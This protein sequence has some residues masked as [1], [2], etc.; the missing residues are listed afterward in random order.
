MISIEEFTE[1]A[2]AFLD[3]HATPRAGTLGPFK[4]GEGSDSVAIVEEKDPE[5]E[6][7]SI[8]E[9][10]VWAQTRWDA[11][12]GWITGP[13]ELGGA[14]LTAEHQRAYRA[15]EHR[16][17][18]P[19]QSIFT[20]GLGMVAPTIAAHATDDIKAQYLPGLHRGD[21]IACQLFSEPGAGSDLAGVSMRAERDGD[22]WILNGQK[23]WTSNAQHSDIGEVICRTDPDAPKHAGITAFVVDMRAPGVEVRPLRQMT[24]GAAF[25]EVFLSDVRVPD[26][27]RLG[28]VNAG[29]GVA[30]TTLLNERAS[31]GSG[32]GLGPGPG[33]FERLIALARITEH[34]NDPIV[35]QQLAQIYTEQRLAALTTAR[36]LAA[37]SKG[38]MPGPELSLAKLAGTK[39]LQRIS[40]FV[41]AVLGP[42]LLADTGEWGTF[43]WGHLVCGVPGGRLGGGTDEVLRNIIGERVL[44]LPK[45]PKV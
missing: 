24:G 13:T 30:L 38:G 5:Q 39:N 37:I 36:Q 19:D 45:E 23:V 29:W 28:D 12:F 40:D 15:L 6:I 26:T 33:P 22:E 14:G 25:N 4:W 21:I 3:A 20:I 11:G 8:K 35:R 34:E 16:Y 31:I 27:H 42:K 17:E 41:S 2:R 44:G 9:A 32:M 43:A 10:R 18:T 1:S 7:I